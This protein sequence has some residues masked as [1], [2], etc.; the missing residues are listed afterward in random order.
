M[1]RAKLVYDSVVQKYSE[2]AGTKLKPSSKLKP[3]EFL[4]PIGEEKS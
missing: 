3:L 1:Y 2:I 4:Q